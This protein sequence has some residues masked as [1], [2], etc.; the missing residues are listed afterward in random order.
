MLKNPE[1]LKHLIK[2]LVDTKSEKSNQVDIL[3]AISW[4]LNTLK[5]DF[6]NVLKEADLLPTLLSY[7][8]KTKFSRKADDV[9]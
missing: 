5:S 1:V 2:L 7:L 4:L 9:K 8:F 6:L 3:K